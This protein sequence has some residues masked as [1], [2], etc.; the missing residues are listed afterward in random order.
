MRHCFQF[1]DYFRCFQFFSLFLASHTASCIVFVPESVGTLIW[2]F[3]HWCLRHV[4]SQCFFVTSQELS[5][6]ST[7][8]PFLVVGHRRRIND[9]FVDG[10]GSYSECVSGQPLKFIR[11]IY[12]LLICW[13]EDKSPKI[14]FCCRHRLWCDVIRSQN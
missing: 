1:Q 7:P 13:F 9:L 12:H 3:Q 2:V 14:V 6:H 10:M 8:V 4:G 11:K 5:N